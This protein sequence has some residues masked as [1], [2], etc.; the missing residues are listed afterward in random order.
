[1]FKL[2]KLH[3]DKTYAIAHPI[4]YKCRLSVVLALSDNL[5]S[6]VFCYQIHNKSTN[7]IH[8]SPRFS[9]TLHS[10]VF[11]FFITSSKS[12]VKSKSLS[13]PSI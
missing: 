7:V 10:H 6:I 3:N 1:M 4:P 13:S 9:L 12:L 5:P 11:R 2:C 8:D